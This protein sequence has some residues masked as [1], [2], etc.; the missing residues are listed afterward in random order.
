MLKAQKWY[1]P[2]A[3]FLSRGGVLLPVLKLFLELPYLGMFLCV[4]PAVPLLG[5]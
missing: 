2:K 4:W 3:M 5:R 1:T